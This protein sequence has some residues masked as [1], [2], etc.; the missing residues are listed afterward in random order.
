MKQCC[1]IV[2]SRCVKILS[3]L[4]ITHDMRQC[5]IIKA[6]MSGPYSRIAL[7][8]KGREDQ[9]HTSLPKVSSSNPKIFS[10]YFSP[11]RFH[12]V[13]KAMCINR[14]I[15]IS[16]Y[17]APS[18]PTIL[19]YDIHMYGMTKQS[20]YVWFYLL[21]FDTACATEGLVVLTCLWYHLLKVVP[22]DHTPAFRMSSMVT[23]ALWALLVAADLVLPGLKT[24][25]AMPA[26]CIAALTHLEIV[27][28]EV[29]LMGLLTVRKSC[30]S[31]PRESNVRCKYVFI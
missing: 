30:F 6:L 18:S 14:D 28:L 19:T 31:V 9:D 13:F 5:C 2:A 11:H 20:I 22:V 17:T 3:K 27:S 10:H 4:L 21:W 1:R 15:A 26:S 12:E 8:T 29:A 25:T 24:D 16:G 23:P 7:Q